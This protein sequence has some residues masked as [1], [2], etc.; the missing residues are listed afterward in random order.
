[1]VA[2]ILA[3]LA[4]AWLVQRFRRRRVVIVHRSLVTDQL[5]TEL[6]RIAEALE[7]IANNPAD[8]V[9][10]AVNQKAE[11]S[12]AMPFSTFDRERPHN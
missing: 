5:L 7:R 4:T 10:A 2:G 3:I 8:Q 1:M 12:R 9:L 6:S 11:E